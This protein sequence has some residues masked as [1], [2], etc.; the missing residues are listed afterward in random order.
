MCGSSILCIKQ[1]TCKHPTSNK[2][3]WPHS[4]NIQT[5]TKSTLRAC[6]ARGF[7]HRLPHQAVQFRVPHIQSRP[8]TMH[9][10]LDPR[11]AFQFRL[12]LSS[13]SLPCSSVAQPSVILASLWSSFPRRA[14]L[15]GGRALAPGRSDAALLRAGVRVRLPPAGCLR[16]PL[17]GLARRLPWLPSALPSAPACVLRLR[18]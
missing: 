12:S 16:G 11:H 8:L 13:S 15:R 10:K 1:T 3:I 6:H 18:S 5:T 14:G 9:F 7:L 17:P 2:N 4:E